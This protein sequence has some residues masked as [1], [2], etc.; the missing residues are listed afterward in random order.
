MTAKNYDFDRAQTF[1][2][3]RLS[4]TTGTHELEVLINSDA[5]PASYQVVDVRFPTSRQT[6]VRTSSSRS[7]AGPASTASW[8]GR[9]PSRWRC[10]TRWCPARSSAT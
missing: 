4:F 9:R 7:A 8:P 10:S 2:Q 3:D 6:A 1:F 5:D